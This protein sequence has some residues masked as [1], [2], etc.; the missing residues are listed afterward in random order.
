MGRAGVPQAHFPMGDGT[1]LRD[2]L[3]MNT[4]SKILS[5]IDGQVVAER[6]LH[7]NEQMLEAVHKAQQAQ[8][9]W[10]N[11]PI[12]KR[13]VHVHDAIEHMLANKAEL[14]REITSQMGRPC[15]YAEGEIQGL[16]ERAFHML[17]IAESQLLDQKVY[18]KTDATQ[19]I[20][21]EPLGLVFTIAPWNY[22]YLTAVNSIVPAL[23]A[24][25]AVLLKHSAQTLLCAER[26]HEAFT[27]AG[28]PEGV[29]QHL[30]LS[31]EQ[32]VELVGHGA[33]KFVSFTG[34][35]GGGEAIEAAASGQFMGVALELGGKDPAY[36]REDANLQY[37]VE[38]IVDGA[39]F[40]SGQSCCGIE[41]VY[42]HDSLYENFVAGVVAQ[43]SQYR[44]GD[45]TN[46]E[47]TL[48]PLVNAKAAG[49]VREQIRQAVADGATAHID[50]SRF[51]A[52]TEDGPYMAPTSADRRRSSYEHN[53]RRELWS[54]GRHH[55]CQW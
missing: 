53:D 45:P 15:R 27:A 54:G 18:G 8:V 41:R 19:F 33:I 52:N 39:F 13:I 30:H 50:P 25:N 29:F 46:P 44:L 36:V 32:T 23:V 55:A 10:R 47:T 3:I 20:R 12:A 26:F 49:H 42:V 2:Y 38:Q 31:H 34:S 16:A 35:V 14:A 9:L 11:M 48:G 37:A 28:L 7:T 6:P 1:L 43:V 21:H 22:P 17:D 4:V 5:P 51:P 40:N 24:G